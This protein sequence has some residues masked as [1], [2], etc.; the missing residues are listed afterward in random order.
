VAGSPQECVD[1]LVLYE[2]EYN[3][4]YVIM[5]FRLPAGPEHSRVPECIQLFGEEVLPRVQE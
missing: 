5:R 1:Q 2:K 3:V 4:D